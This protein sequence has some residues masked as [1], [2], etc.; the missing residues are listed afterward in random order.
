MKKKKKKKE[1]AKTILDNGHNTW[2]SKS[3]PKP[4]DF[5]KIKKCTK[6]QSNLLFG[7]GTQEKTFFGSSYAMPRPK[8]LIGKRAYARLD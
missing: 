8:I 6:P 4:H 1:E 2:L 7:I 3:S 5:P